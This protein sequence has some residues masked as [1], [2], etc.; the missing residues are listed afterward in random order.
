[1]NDMNIQNTFTEYADKLVR[2]FIKTSRSMR[3]E[4]SSGRAIID[5]NFW[6][7][8]SILNAKKVMFELYNYAKEIRDRQE[9]HKALEHL[10][11]RLAEHPIIP[12][13]ELRD[14]EEPTP[15]KPLTDAIKNPDIQTPESDM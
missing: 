10:E 11:N 4:R 2:E 8:N 9:I 13:K 6:M 7:R 14:P 1:M 15:I 12:Q 3:I 5:T